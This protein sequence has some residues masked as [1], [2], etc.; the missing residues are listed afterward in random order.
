MNKKR[1]PENRLIALAAACSLILMTALTGC[2]GQGSQDAYRPAVS[3]TGDVEQTVTLSPDGTGS[4]TKSESAAAAGDKRSGWRLSSLIDEAGEYTEE[5]AVYIQGWDGMMAS[6]RLGELDENWL[7]FG[8]NGW[9]CVSD[10]YPESLAVKEIRRV[11]VVADDPDDVPCAVT[12]TAE[13]GLERTLSP[14]SLYLRDAV[15]SISWQGESSK[16][17]RSVSVWLTDSYAQ[18][19]E[20][21]LY[22]DG[23]T[24]ADMD[25]TADADDSE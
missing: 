6:I 12:V 19:G 8:E 25:D 3:I 7:V 16:N 10:G 23:N 2:A 9:E 24:I 11:I 4:V 20:S 15:S 18:I 1:N 17:D 13:D 14:G 21:R 22:A 5:S